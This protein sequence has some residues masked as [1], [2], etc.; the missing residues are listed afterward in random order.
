MTI[1]IGVI[2]IVLATYASIVSTVTLV[3]RYRD[4]RDIENPVICRIDLAPHLH[5]GTA[6]F[7]F[8]VQNRSTSKA[9]IDR[10]YLRVSRSDGSAM[11]RHQINSSLRDDF[12]ET[13]EPGEQI[14]FRECF[15]V[16]NLENGKADYDFD[17]Q[18]YH[19]RS[20]NP[21]RIVMRDW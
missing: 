1:V 17:I 18:V 15:E 3:F 2:S 16:P 10:I 13:Y 9:F 7:A 6:N 21:A 14:S 19:S 5:E 4:R 8:T 11:Y 20:E 12:K